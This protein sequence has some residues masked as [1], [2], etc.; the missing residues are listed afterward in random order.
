[1]FHRE[2]IERKQ[3]LAILR[4]AFLRLF[5]PVFFGEDLDR[6]LGSRAVFGESQASRSSSCRVARNGRLRQVSFANR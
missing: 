2:G 4:Q 5:R 1:M 3:R 6:R